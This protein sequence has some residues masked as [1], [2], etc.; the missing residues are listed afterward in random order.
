M[1]KLFNLTVADRSVVQ[2]VSKTHEYSRKSFRDVG[3]S[4]SIK[5]V[6]KNKGN[7]YEF[8]PNSTSRV[9]PDMFQIDKFLSPYID[10][11]NLLDVGSGAG[12]II[13][14]ARV[15]DWRGKGI[16]YD[17]G[18]KKISSANTIYDTEYVDAFDY[19]E[20][21]DFDIIYFYQPIAT[22]ELM[23]KLLDEI[24]SQ[25]TKG[26]IIMA[27]DADE[28]VHKHVNKL[29]GKVFHDHWYIR[30]KQ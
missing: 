28:R 11:P 5:G 29:W 2:A 26:T 3:K 8:I 4:N 19:E 7:Y 9:L 18:Y 13:N 17:E 14:L 21:D 30:I 25:I 15:M 12:N 24:D 16:E 6:V 23:N 22:P 10:R 20:Y 27:Y 1:R